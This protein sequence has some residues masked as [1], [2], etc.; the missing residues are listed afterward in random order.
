MGSLN[1]VCQTLWIS[2]GS[3]LL[4]MLFESFIFLLDFFFLLNL[5]II[6]DYLNIT[7]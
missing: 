4:I 5:L 1:V 3:H 6:K 7:L 2:L